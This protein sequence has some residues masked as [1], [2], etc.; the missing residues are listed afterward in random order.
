M[1]VEVLNNCFRNC[2]SFPNIYYQNHVKRLKEDL[3]KKEHMLCESQERERR[4]K[5]Q[6]ETVLRD[7]KHEKEEVA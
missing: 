4:L 6:N 5:V 3:Q 1:Y 2:N 7:L